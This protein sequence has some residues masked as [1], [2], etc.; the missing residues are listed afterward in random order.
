MGGAKKVVDK[1]IERCKDA[2]K[3]GLPIIYIKTDSYELI[4]SIV[5]SE[6][7]V[8]LLSEKKSD[9]FSRSQYRPYKENRKSSPD[10]WKEKLDS[11]Y[12]NCPHIVTISASNGVNEEE[13]FRYIKAYMRKES[14]PDIEHLTHIY[15]SSVIILYSN[16]IKISEKLRQYCEI[17]EVGYPEN[18]EI[19]EKVQAI[20]AEAG[21][22]IDGRPLQRLCTLLQ[23]FTQQEIVYS[24]NKVLTR[25]VDIA[26]ENNGLLVDRRG[27]L[28]PEVRRIIQEQKK[29]KLQDGNQV[30]KLIAYEDDKIGGMRELTGYINT[31]KERKL[32]ED[33]RL[34]KETYGLQAP[35]GILLCGI[36][37]CGK[38]L[39]AKLTAQTLDLPLLQMD[40]GNL[41]GGIQG[42]SE[43]NM[44]KA[45]GLAE[46]MAPCVLWID[47]LEKGFSGAK[48][49]GNSDGGTFKRMFGTL[50]NWMQENMKPCFIFATANDIGGL[51]KELFRSGRFDEL[52]AVYLPTAQ[53]CADIFLARVEK[54]VESTKEFRN[55]SAKEPLIVKEALNT[56]LYLELINTCL[57]SDNGVRIV[58]GSDIQKIVNLALANLS[59]DLREEG[60]ITLK[61]WKDALREEI[62]NASVYGDSPE[63]I[64][65]IA[66]GYCR[67]LRK[68]LRPTVKIPLFKTRD[69]H[70]ENALKSKGD[71]ADGQQMIL[72]ENKPINL[73]KYDIAVY[74]LLYPKINEWAYEVERYERQKLL[75]G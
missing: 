14:S 70:C 68:G 15:N 30:L 17:V 61:E 55:N 35:K 56:E 48:S 72:V 51:P 19:R 25:D 21:E 42:Q 20:A 41:M 7:L 28:V 45:L 8:L 52:F 24:L 74:S 29:Q 65:S 13:L 58:I 43:E 1:V 12:W 33:A 23:G 66:V 62:R 4:E 73:E 54:A 63:N 22:R 71:G 40:M 37:G 9:K 10:N 67:M 27:D 44:R 26:K 59:E 57:I 53:E 31:I 6:K 36:P 16:Q 38:S 39:A 32:L 69:Y 60:S 34:N 18:D 50:L 64:D 75:E 5:Y 49:S 3:A 46:A 47:E 2:M 11:T